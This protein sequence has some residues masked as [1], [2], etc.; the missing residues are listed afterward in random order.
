MAHR[1]QV[2]RT[3]LSVPLGKLGCA[4]STE[5]NQVQGGGGPLHAILL[6]RHEPVTD[7]DLAFLK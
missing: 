4:V 6:L 2:G 5:Q 7:A 1:P 3:W